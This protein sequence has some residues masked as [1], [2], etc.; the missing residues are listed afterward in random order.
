MATIL[1]SIDWGFQ[2]LDWLSSD[3][4]GAFPNNRGNYVKSAND[5]LRYQ[6]VWT[7]GGLTEATEPSMLNGTSTTGDVLYV[8]FIVQVCMSIEDA[9]I[10]G[11]ET[12]AEIT[13]TRDIANK[14]YNTDAVATGHKFTV[15]VSQIVSS[16]LSYSLCPIGKGTWRSKVTMLVLVIPNRS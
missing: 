7:K 1:G 8:K 15:D 14:K 10:N 4:G 6:L 5:P 12:L 16:E 2:P 11:W 9:N 3:L 13:K